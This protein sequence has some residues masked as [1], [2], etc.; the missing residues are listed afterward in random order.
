MESISKDGT[1]KHRKAIL[2]EKESVW[3]QQRDCKDLTKRLEFLV[4]FSKVESAISVNK[5]PVCLSIHLSKVT[6]HVQAVRQ[7]LWNAHASSPPA[8]SPNWLQREGEVAG[9]RRQLLKC[10]QS[11]I[12]GYF[13]NLADCFDKHVNKI[14]QVDVVYITLSQTFDRVPH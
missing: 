14:D 11:A 8:P 6:T 10:T 3:P 4:H 7:N 9:P 13:P 5:M 2:A 1:I 12:C